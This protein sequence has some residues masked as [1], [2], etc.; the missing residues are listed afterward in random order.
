[1]SEFRDYGPV[2]WWAFGGVIEK[3]ELLRQFQLLQ[4]YGIDEFFIYQGYGLYEPD[5]LSEEWFDI[6]AF[7]IEEAKKRNMHVWIYD[8]LNWPSGTAGG[9]FPR[10]FPE[11]RIK[12]IRQSLFT[13]SPG[14]VFGN[15]G[16][17][18]LLRMYIRPTDE[19]N[20]KWTRVELTD[21]IYVNDTGKEV[22]LQCFHISVASGMPPS[23]GCMG[24]RSTWNQR[25]ICD[26]LNPKAVRAWMSCIHDKYYE[27]FKDECGK[28]LRGFFYDEPTSIPGYGNIPYTD[29][30]DEEFQQR[31][32]YNYFD[33]LTEFYEDSPGSE[34][35][36]Y[37]FWTFVSEHLAISFSKT[38]ADWCAERHLESTGHCVYEEIRDQNYR[39]FFSGNIPKLQSYQQIPA[40]DMLCDNTPFHLGKG[41]PWYGKTIEAAHGFIFTAKQVTST[42]RYSGAKRVLAEA[43]GVCNPNA[44]ARRVKIVWDWLTGA[45]VNMFNLNGLGY[46]GKSF[47]KRTGSNESFYQP[48]MRQYATMSAFVRETSKAA[49]GRLQAKVAVLDPETTIRTFTWDT[50]QHVR[51]IPPKANVSGAVLGAMVALMEAHIDQEL[52]FEDVLLQSDVSGGVIHAPNSA[53]EVLILPKAVVLTDELA[54]KIRKF[55]SEG[56]KVYCIEKR[57]TRTPDDLPHEFSDLP[58]V[59]PAELPAL[60]RRFI[61]FP[62][63]IEGT[64][65]LYTALRDCDGVPTLFLA[66]MGEGA[67]DVKVKTESLPTP[68]VAKLT[69]DE[70]WQL[71]GNEIH[72]EPYQSIFLR[73][74]QT[75]ENQTPPIT[76]GPRRKAACLLEGPWKYDI[77]KPNNAYPIYEVGLAPN[78]EKDDINKVQLWLPCTWDGCHDMEFAPKECPYYWLRSQFSVEDESVLKGLSLLFER[79]EVVRVFVNGKEIALDSVQDYCLWTYEV[80]KLDISSAAKMGVNSLEV[81]CETSYWNALEK[82]TIFGMNYIEPCVLH[83]NF[84]TA[85]GDKV[86]RLRKMPDTLALGDI[87]KQGFPWLLGDVNY[88]VVIDGDKATTLELPD[89]GEATVDVTLNGEKLGTR[90]WDPFRFELAGKL[91]PGKNELTIT[92]PTNWGNFYPRGYAGRRVTLTP[93]GLMVP[94]ELG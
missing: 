8:D 67:A 11:Y 47:T 10:N 48:W 27:R 40:M 63:T 13:L 46:S 66:N 89:I 12:S 54:D 2:P 30:L 94:P 25:G 90:L 65:E 4:D 37:E 34:K 81:L 85:I 53:F 71:Q 5:F 50:G 17:D 64:G 70:P 20:G 77:S 28:T 72:L 60:I 7:I 22:T 15:S 52:I 51:T 41:H 75:C 55:H 88:H 59:E 26:L 56:G 84:A 58:L 76:W 16:T 24:T 3:K 80:V 35:F 45:G 44:P 92:I 1:M 21:N 29:G 78:E 42:A 61:K 57:P 69:G 31:Y 14:E 19:P 91:R 36:R 82:R 62:Y 49:T 87:G 79:G 43:M 32:G 39:L 68:V 33:H 86:V 38:I 9:I 83:G 93:I 23:L 73:Y 74:G 6:V 18:K